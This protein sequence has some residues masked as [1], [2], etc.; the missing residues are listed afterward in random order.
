MT[1]SKGPRYFVRAAANYL[2]YQVPKERPPKKEKKATELAM[3]GIRTF[4]QAIIE[5]RAPAADGKSGTKNWWYLA[6]LDAWNVKQE[7]AP[8]RGR[9]SK[10]EVADAA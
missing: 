7:N 5:G 3:R 6:T 8:R 9:K 2:G 10:A 1:Q 4:Y